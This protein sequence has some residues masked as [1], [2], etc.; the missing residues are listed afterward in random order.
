MS[1]LSLGGLN[2]VVE[3]VCLYHTCFLT[4]SL[5]DC[6]SR[7]TLKWLLLR[8]HSIHLQRS[9][10][11][12]IHILLIPHFRSFSASFNLWMHCGLS[13][14][15][16]YSILATIWVTTMLVTYLTGAK[17]Q[18]R[19]NFWRE[20]LCMCY[21]TAHVILFSLLILFIPVLKVLSFYWNDCL[22][23]VII[24]YRINTRIS[25][26]MSIWF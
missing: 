19:S 13:I 26:A 9:C 18:Q 2:G 10:Q 7:M 11:F 23:L 4:T 6:Q 24:F 5:T 20:P 25:L 16:T 3:R 22:Q 21:E 17:R 14:V 15:I 1:Y 12:Y 8:S